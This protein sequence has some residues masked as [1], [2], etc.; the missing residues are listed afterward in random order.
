MGKE[1]VIEGPA[2]L[3]RT[4]PISSAQNCPS[5]QYAGRRSG[6]PVA[7]PLEPLVEHVVASATRWG[8]GNNSEAIILAIDALQGIDDVRALNGLALIVLC[9]ADGHVQY[10][11]EKRLE[12]TTVCLVHFTRE[13]SETAAH[14]QAP[15]GG[16]GEALDR[17][18]PAC[19][20]V[21]LC[22]RSGN[23]TVQIILM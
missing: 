6:R 2:T 7:R 16:L 4:K 10:D 1:G 22:Y 14:G 9:V 18:L 11:F 12:N 23:H 19:A 3:H 21:S 13:T 15:D 17:L 5:R 20:L 8:P